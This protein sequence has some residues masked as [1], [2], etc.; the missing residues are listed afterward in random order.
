[1]AGR[2]SILLPLG[3]GHNTWPTQ[4]LN[5]RSLVRSS[6]AKLCMLSFLI[7]DGEIDRLYSHYQVLWLFPN[8]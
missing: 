7:K 4:G 3:I 6:T 5:S 1:M 2:R 8:P